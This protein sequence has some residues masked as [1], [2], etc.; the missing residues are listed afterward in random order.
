MCSKKTCHKNDCPSDNMPLNSHT[1]HSRV[2][3]LKI[4]LKVFFLQGRML[5]TAFLMLS[6][7]TQFLEDT[8]KMMW[9]NLPWSFGNS[10]NPENRL[11]SV[12]FSKDSGITAIVWPVFSSIQSMPSP[13]AMNM[14]EIKWNTCKKHLRMHSWIRVRS[15][16]QAEGLQFCVRQHINPSGRN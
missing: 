12:N 14:R 16:G 6:S 2:H 8:Q 15:R 7:F 13:S 5:L 4:V 1:C 3:K 10:K 9:S 11:R